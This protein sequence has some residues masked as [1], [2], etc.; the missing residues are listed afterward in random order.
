MKKLCPELRRFVRSLRSQH[1]H[2]LHRLRL[3]YQV[4]GKVLHRSPAM[5]KVLHLSPAMGFLLLPLPLHLVLIPPLAMEPKLV[6]T[7]LSAMLF[8][9]LF[10]VR[11]RPS[12]I[13]TPRPLQRAMAVL[14]R[15]PLGKLLF[16]TSPVT[17]SENFVFYAN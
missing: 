8:L 10:L 17:K 7:T 9:R 5:G 2:S 14:L 13:V 1:M 6:R 12:V 15:L 3:L 16:R 11:T 4:T